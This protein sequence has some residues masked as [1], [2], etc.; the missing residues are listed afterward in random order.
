MA[1]LVVDRRLDTRS[2]RLKLAIR[3]EPH[4]RTITEG[5][6]LGYRRG[7]GTWIARR[8]S[9]G[10]GRA[11][12][13]IGPADDV[14]DADGSTVLTFAQAQERARLWAADLVRATEG[15]AAAPGRLAVVDQVLTHYMDWMRLHRRSEQHAR[16]VWNGSI[17][18][19][20][21]GV[22]VA[23]LTPSRLRAWHESLARS[24][25]RRRDGKARPGDPE[26]DEL[27]RRKATANRNL[28][29][30]K[31]ALNLAYR[32]GLLES[33][34]A[35]R[36][37]KP[38][39]AVDVPRVR[40]LTPA[41]LRALATAC[42]PDL[43]ALVQAAALTGCRFGELAKLRVGDFDKRA[44]T[45]TLRE[46]KNGKPRHVALTPE[47]LRLF[48]A[49]AAGR[50]REAWMLLTAAGTAWTQANHNRPLRAACAAAGIKPHASFHILR[51]SFA[52]R[53]AMRGVS[54]HVIGEHLGHS[55][56]RI[57][58]RH[59]AH[60]APS[61]VADTVRSSLGSFGFK[62]KP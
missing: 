54:L 4:W 24:K 18:P 25:P 22:L 27:R 33:D 20:F 59:Y 48:S 13:A 52:S 51:H 45:L 21:A 34:L 35:W 3:R 2:A 17:K 30:F 50:E 55:D 46:T 41:E 19:H 57:T 23:E 7:P 11:Y 38:F 39:R 47:G 14:V 9:A 44:K 58:Q 62:V 53:L 8:Y 42:A 60:L 37:V 31:A 36:S 49:L 16:W 40:Y 32:E 5:L 10:A 12:F 6:A 1:R 61:Y 26:G 29:V 28:S 15:P 43:R 56:T